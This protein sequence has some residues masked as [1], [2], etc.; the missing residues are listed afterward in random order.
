MF[1]APLA[2]A[3]LLAIPGAYPLPSG[4]VPL[5]VQ[6]MA[7]DPLPSF[8][9]RDAFILGVEDGFTAPAGSIARAGTEAYV[10]APGYRSIPDLPSWHPEPPATPE[11]F[12]AVGDGRSDDTHALADAF[13]TGTVALRPG[14]TYGFT[15]L[16]VPKNSTVTGSGARLRYLGKN[17]KAPILIIW[18][19][20]NWD[21][22][23]YSAGAQTIGGEK[24]RSRSATT[25]A[26]ADSISR[27]MHRWMPWPSR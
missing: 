24:A 14:R 11:H 9:S 15:S 26:S 4:A 1:I 10:A 7:G 19:S 17:R 2:A 18:A 16:D 5:R 20:T 27:R 21:D 22:L 3:W 13:A 12:G 8:A 6:A 25:S 23:H